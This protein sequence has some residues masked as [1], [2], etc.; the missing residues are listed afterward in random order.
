MKKGLA[1]KKCLAKCQPDCN[2]VKHTISVEKTPLD[3]EKSICANSD[4][5]TTSEKSIWR[6]IFG[7]GQ[8]HAKILW[9]KETSSKTLAR[10]LQNRMFG[11]NDTMENIKY[12]IGK[13]SMD[14]AVVNVVVNS[15]TVQKLVQDVKTTFSDK[16]AIFG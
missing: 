12:C 11:T 1:E 14:I 16:L 10:T 6:H 3:L 8:I 5:Y 13:V 15:P 9:N 2:E 4:D 7:E